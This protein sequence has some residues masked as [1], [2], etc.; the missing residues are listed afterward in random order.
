[1]R[2]LSQLVKISVVV[3]WFNRDPDR[4]ASWQ[5]LKRWY[6]I[7]MPGTEL[8]ESSP[9]NDEDF[10]KP[11]LVNRGVQ[12]ASGDVV[13]IT[14]ADVLP[15]EPGVLQK[16][17]EQATVASWVVP[18][19]QVL[20]LRP[21]PT[22]QVLSEPVVGVTWPT[23]PLVRHPYRGIPGGGL[24][25]ISRDNFLAMGGFDPVFTGWGGEDSAFGIAADCLLGMHVRYDHVPLLHFYHDPGPRSVDPRYSHNISRVEAYRALA[26]N[27]DAMARF[28]GIPT[29]PESKLLVSRPSRDDDIF[30][31]I[32][33]LNYLGVKVGQH[34]RGS[35]LALMNHAMNNEWRAQTTSA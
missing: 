20:R 6:R 1:M 4:E 10:N 24:I 12:R 16:A 3:P 22:A 17:A 29:P 23:G 15:T 21:E 25:V 14:D 9:E 35:K 13:I 28:R 19:G 11:N 26:F 2:D 7:N 33:Y 32:L 30:E 5:W 27:R 34:M 31:W 18:H 8:I